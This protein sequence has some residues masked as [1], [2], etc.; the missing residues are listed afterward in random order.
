[1]NLIKILIAGIGFGSLFLI[2]KKYKLA[3]GLVLTAYLIFLGVM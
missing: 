1:M 2:K 3:L